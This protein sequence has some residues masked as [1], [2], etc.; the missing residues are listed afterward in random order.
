MD[1]DMLRDGVHIPERAF[2]GAGGI[3]GSRTTGK[4]HEVHRLDGA[5]YRMPARQPYLGPLLNCG[6][7]RG[8]HVIP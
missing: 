7:A 5:R 1:A 6:L 2:D 4:I 3:Q 8:E